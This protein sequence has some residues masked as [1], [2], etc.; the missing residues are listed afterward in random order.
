ME[1][2]T[3]L[4]SSYLNN[5]IVCI[6]QSINVVMI[7]SSVKLEE[8]VKNEYIDSVWVWKRYIKD[9]VK[10]SFVKITILTDA[11]RK[12]LFA[13]SI[14]LDNLAVIW[15][16]LV[17]SCCSLYIFVHLQ[18]FNKTSFCRR[19]LSQQFQFFSQYNFFSGN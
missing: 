8:H 11:L 1:I 18:S 19:Y 14:L 17:S 6:N 15:N 13:N 12:Q 3:K 16:I 9:Q 5:T 7:I 4:L 10:D 2:H